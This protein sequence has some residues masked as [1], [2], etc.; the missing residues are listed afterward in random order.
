MACIGMQLNNGRWFRY[1]AANREENKSIIE[2]ST[3][4]VNY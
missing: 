3:Q 4:L 1:P 2:I